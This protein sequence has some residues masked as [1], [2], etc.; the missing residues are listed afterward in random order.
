MN[1]RDPKLTALMFNERINAR[2]VEGLSA[3]MTDDHRFVDREGGRHAGKDRMTE[4]WQTFFE[5][6]TAV[7]LD[8]LIAEWRVY[9]DTEHNR[10][11]L[12]GASIG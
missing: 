11:R 12:A 10:R 9:E 2:D 1:S 8:D 7:V 4:G 5:I 3:L 6:W